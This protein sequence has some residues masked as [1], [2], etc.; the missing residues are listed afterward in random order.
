MGCC[1][2]KGKEFHEAVQTVSEVNDIVNQQPWRAVSSDL[3]KLGSCVKSLGEA[4]DVFKMNAGRD[5][6]QIKMVEMLA[7]RLTSELCFLMDIH[8]LRRRD[9]LRKQE[10]LRLARAL[11]G[12]GGESFVKASSQVEQKK[13]ELQRD[14]AKSFLQQVVLLLS[15]LTLSDQLLDGAKQV[16]SL[17]QRAGTEVNDVPDLVPQLMQHSAAL[18]AKMLAMVT[19]L[20]DSDSKSLILLEDLSVQLDAL[21]G[22]FATGGSSWDDVTPQLL[23]TASVKAREVVPGK[24][25]ILE[26][27]LA[28]EKKDFDSQLLLKT[29]QDMSPWCVALPPELEDRIRVV[30]QQVAMRVSHAFD[31]AL[32]N[33]VNG[34]MDRL[35]LFAK[36]YDTACDRMKDKPDDST[37]L[38][39]DLERKRAGVTLED[40]IKRARESI[41][42]QCEQLRTAF[43]D[44]QA[45]IKKIPRDKYAERATPPT[46]RFRLRSGVFKEYSEAKSAEVEAHYQAWVKNG[47]PSADPRERRCQISIK[48]DIPAKRAG[49][50][51]SLTPGG[52]KRCKYG[53]KCYQKNSKHR[54][55]FAHPGDQDYIDKEWDGAIEAAASSAPPPERDVVEKGISGADISVCA[56]GS[57]LREEKF[58]LDFSMMTQVNLTRRAGMRIVKRVEGMTFSQ[59][60]TSAYFDKV[61]D[62]VQG[63]ETMFSKADAEMRLL[64]SVEREAMRSQ[65]DQLLKSIGPSVHDFMKIAVKIGDMKTIEEIVALL[66]PRAEPL[67]LSDLLK[68]LR[69]NDVIEEFRQVYRPVDGRSTSTCAGGGGTAILRKPRKWHLLR[70]L[71]RHKLLRPRFALRATQ[72]AFQKRDRRRGYM[73]CQA[74]LAE[75]AADGEFCERFRK[76]I[77]AVLASAAEWHAEN[78]LPDAFEAIVKTAKALQC[79]TYPVLRI[80]GKWAYWAT[81]GACNLQLQSLIRI[82]EVL[83]IAAAIAKTGGMS[84]D[85]LFEIKDLIPRIAAKAR[86][87][88]DVSEAGRIASVRQIVG[89]AV[90]LTYT[91]HS[92][93]D[94][95][96]AACQPWY[97]G[98]PSDTQ[99]VLAV[100]WTIAF[101][102]QLKVPLPKWMMKKDQLEALRKLQ[103]ALESG[104]EKDLREAVVFAKQADYKCEANIV[105]AYDQA[106]SK[107]KVLKRLP[108]GWEVADMVGDDAATQMF[109]QA[110]LDSPT[111]I[112]LFQKFF[113]DTKASIVTRDRVGAVPGGY[114]VQ[115]V[116]SV[117]NADSW[118]SYLRRRDEIAQECKRFSGAAPCPDETWAGWS[119]KLAT[120]GR[121]RDILD[122][123]KV[124]QLEGNAN[125]FLL[126]HGTKPDAADLIAKDHFDM[127]FACKTGLFGAGLYLAEN[128]SKSDE[129]V[130]PDGAMQ[131]PMI[132][133]R[134]TLGRMNYCAN[135]DPIKDPGRDKLESSCLRGEYHSVIGDRKKAKGT[136][137]EF[138]V[139]DHYQVYPHFIVWYTRL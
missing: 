110:D 35:L 36:E 47:S 108:S 55:E 21:C 39:K 113:D 81:S 103:N 59:K 38:V 61:R 82:M 66:G 133:C 128:C 119:G 13:L 111:L 124:P 91:T 95:F 5:A 89:L 52:R 62:F 84:L 22:K 83:D 31:E 102:E 74:L 50:S 30:C 46:W 121:A 6:E 101:C 28:K 112:S 69:H 45:N 105:K 130:K 100:E 87:E 99:Q 24:L 88:I 49:S 20:M 53:D 86:S 43:V 64:D 126:F 115:R 56:S 134:V 77:S 71:L 10:I 132:V 33:G 40:M 27:E 17:L 98:L 80:A 18:A 32:G 58:S 70:N 90:K 93:L 107:L 137:R 23:Q 92:F 125:E 48:V 25:T 97:E 122:Q 68:E 3:S 7:A 96:W 37:L 19:A 116:V 57:E 8:L 34:G 127:S 131:Y 12:L 73:R 54:S 106:M 78:Q 26:A 63:N 85:A 14:L 72:I 2:G 16:L 11:D 44:A 138:I 135:L 114:R 123:C 65:V 79:E 41:S 4:N 9:H 94:A 67:G 75:Y 118:G 42:V 29:F 136:Y 51:A 76:D 139:Y 104:G 129:Y 60:A 15:Q 117:M 1:P 109:K 120:A